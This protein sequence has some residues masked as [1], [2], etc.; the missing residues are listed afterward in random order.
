[1]S[2]HSKWSTIKHKKAVTD[3]K[4]A[5]VFT[6]LAKDVTIAAREGGDPEMNFK[7]RMAIDKAKAGNMPKENI[8]RA[9]K[10]GT[11]ELKDGSQIEE[12]VYEAYGPGNVAMLIKVTTDNKNRTY[13]EIKNIVSKN[14]GKMVEGGSVSWQFE[15]V[16]LLKAECKE[17]D[18][19]LEMKIIE[20]GAKDY[21]YADPGY[22]IFTDPAGLQQ[23]KNLLEKEMEITQASLVFRAKEKAK[24][25]GKELEAYL[26][27]YELLDEHDDVSEIF[28]NLPE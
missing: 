6:K 22:Q 4:R 2:G 18:E 28:D 26:G 3:A 23:T 8:E 15:Q 1:M 14:G 13:A 16:G 11:G 10:R 7:L 21:S 20:S 25:E 24:P 9:V 27:L 12:A 17:R 5:N 19:E